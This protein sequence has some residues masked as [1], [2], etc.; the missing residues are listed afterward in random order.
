MKNALK[1]FMAYDAC[2]S[3]TIG[4]ADSLENLLKKLVEKDKEWFVNRM[5]NP[6]VE[7]VYFSVKEQFGDDDDAETVDENEVLDLGKK[8]GIF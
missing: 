7:S 8:L 2:S 4:R 6:K 1:E 5:T 3:E